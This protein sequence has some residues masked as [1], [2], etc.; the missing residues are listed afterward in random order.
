MAR[1]AH[2]NQRKR[3][4]L[5]GLACQVLAGS[6]PLRSGMA[7]PELQQ[8]LGEGRRGLNDRGNRLSRGIN[9]R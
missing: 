5:R 3:P 8:H 1:N 9:R 6:Q 4:F 2:N 7:P